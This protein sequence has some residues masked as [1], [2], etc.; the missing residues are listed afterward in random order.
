MVLYTIFS[1]LEHEKETDAQI[2][3]HSNHHGH[4]NENQWQE[5]LVR[6]VEKKNLKTQTRTAFGS[7]YTNSRY[8][9]KTSVSAYNSDTYRLICIIALLTTARIQKQPRD[10][11]HM[12][13]KRKEEK[14][15]KIC[16]A[17]T[18]HCILSLAQIEL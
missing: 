2:P 18:M 10:S 3:A 15:R 5:M 7:S 9:P 6:T 8:T 13:K 1:H 17:Y 14:K 16:C 11:S 12:G 4:Y